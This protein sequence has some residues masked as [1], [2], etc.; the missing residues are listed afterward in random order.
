[1]KTLPLILCCWILLLGLTS[2]EK[3]EGLIYS[4]KPVVGIPQIWVEQKGPDVLRYSNYIKSLGLKNVSPY[5]VLYPHFKKRGD[6]SNN[7]PPRHMWKNIAETLKVVDQLATILKVKVKPFVLVYK[8]PAY[9]RVMRGRSRSQHLVNKAVRVV[10]EGVPPKKVA[11]LARKL[12]AT[13]FFKGGVGHY[14]KF[15]QI[16]TRGHNADW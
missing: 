12:R 4:T 14:S 16:D 3:K 13:G 10:F 6:V 2:A 7:L 8:S 15:T 11:A 5:M 9:N 1:M